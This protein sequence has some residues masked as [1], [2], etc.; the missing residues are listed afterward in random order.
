MR[1]KKKKKRLKHVKKKRKKEEKRKNECLTFKHIWFFFSPNSFPQKPIILNKY[2]LWQSINYRTPASDMSQGLSDSTRPD[3]IWS[4][5]DTV[6]HADWKK[7]TTIIISCFV[8][9][10]PHE[11][12]I[13]E[14]RRPEIRCW[15]GADQSCISIHKISL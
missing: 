1:R 12:I 10:L 8:I 15:N 3:V 13:I 2:D 7:M 5:S 4:E 9:I 14:K 6:E 11:G